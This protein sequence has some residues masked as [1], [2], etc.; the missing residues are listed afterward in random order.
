MNELAKQLAIEINELWDERNWC[1]DTALDKTIK[2]G[3]KIKQAKDSMAHGGFGKWV[4]TDPDHVLG[5]GSLG[6]LRKRRPGR[7]DAS[8]TE[9]HPNCGGVH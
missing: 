5:G 2:I 3:E 7:M 8:A 9:Y 4:G 6:M 1:F